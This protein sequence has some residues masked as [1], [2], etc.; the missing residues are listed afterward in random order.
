MELTINLPETVDFESRGEEFAFA[1]ADVAK[2]K[3]AAFVAQCVVIGISK[4]GVDAASSA[5]TYAKEN[6]MTPEAATR[7]LVDKKMSVWKTGEWSARGTGEGISRVE[8]IAREQVRNA[9]ATSPQLKAVY[10]A[11]DTDGRKAMVEEYWAKQSPESKDA[12][13]QWAKGELAKRQAE[14]A[15]KAEAAKAAS[16]IKIDINL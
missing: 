13:M 11:C 6:G 8:A 3:L 12:A 1:F 7:V 15:R 5:A 9:I 14:S 2:D 10:K 16:G 4:A